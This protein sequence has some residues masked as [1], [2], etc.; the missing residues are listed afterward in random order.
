V[1]IPAMLLLLATSTADKP[2][3]FLILFFGQVLSWAGVPALGA[4]AMGTAGVLAHKGVV[5]LWAVLVVGTIGAEL[6]GMAGWWLGN[7]IARLNL[8]GDGRFAGRRRNALATG[9][10]FADR[11]GRFMVFFTPSWVPGALG[12]PFGQ[13]ARWNLAAAALW[14]IGAG[15]SAYGVA[16]AV[17][18]GSLLDSVPP[19][20]IAVLALIAIF[21][22]GL[23][24]HRR[25]RGATAPAS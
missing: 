10:R 16:S 12:M 3:T 15:L 2:T 14:N 5:H 1:K 8:D 13:F 6:G 21:V 7:R 9:E 18:G 23:H 24:H 22:L 20:V 11:W 17:G 19:L 4:A 25:R